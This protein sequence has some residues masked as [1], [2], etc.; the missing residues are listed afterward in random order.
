MKKQLCD[1]NVSWTKLYL[2]HVHGTE[3]ALQDRI[4]SLL[5]SEPQRA[6]YYCALLDKSKYLNKIA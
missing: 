3:E 6:R 2:E 1:P 4:W 5:T